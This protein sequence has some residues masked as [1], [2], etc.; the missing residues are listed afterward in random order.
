MRRFT[1]IVSTTSIIAVAITGLGLAS[2]AVSAAGT[3]KS[4]IEKGQEIAFSR[5]K[6]NCLACHSIKGGKLPGNIAPPLVAMQQRFPDKAKLRLQIFDSTVANPNSIMPP[7]GRHKII[8][9]K[10]IDL[11]T[12]FI[13]QL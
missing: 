4:D 12:E 11:V 9:D 1:R 8:S 5:K 7:F 2:T 6:G 13:Y 10:E 3:S